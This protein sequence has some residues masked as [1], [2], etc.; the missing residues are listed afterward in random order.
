MQNTGVSQADNVSLTDNVDSRLIVT[1]VSEGDYTCPDGDSNAQTITCTLA[2]LNTGDTKGITVTYR[3]ASSTPAAPSVSNTANSTADDGGAGSATDSVEI[4]TKADVADLKTAASTVI[5]G[6]DLTFQIDVTN[7]GPSDAQNVVLNDTLD[8]Q[9]TNA[10]YCEGSGCTPSAAWTGSDILGTVPAG[11]TVHVTIK[12]TVNP[13]TTQGYAIHNTATVS[14]VTPDPNG[15]NN[16]SSTTTTVQTQADLSV[17]KTAPLTA[18]AGD[19]AGFNFTLGVH[20]FGPSDNTGGFHVTDTLDPRLTFQSTGSSPACSAVGQ[21]VTCTN[22]TGLAASG[23][24]FFTVHVTLDSTVDSGTVIAN[25]ASVASD[26]TV[27]PNAANNTSG[28]TSTTV[29]EDVHLSVTKTFDSDTATAGGDPET[30]TI[31]VHNS[32]LSDA[33]NVVLTDSVD[34]RL[35]VDSTSGGLTCGRAEPV[36]QLHALRISRRV[37]RRR[38]SSRTTSTRPR[39]AIP[40]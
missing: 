32:G 5:A 30:F 19:P 11:T 28:G 27:D 14:S 21:V 3:V 4:T 33:D 37:P 16:D 38:W 34:P 25:T 17:G 29:T 31:A 10:M 36:A 24:Q 13:N 7:N 40:R 22:N 6:N 1:G 2:H 9:L 15:G 35:I 18:T 26:G 23:N 39:T 20:N 12:A 8:G